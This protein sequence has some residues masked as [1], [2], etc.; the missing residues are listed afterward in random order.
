MSA[1]G[2]IGQPAAASW[3]HSV[4][5]DGRKRELCGPCVV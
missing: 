5:C 2:L 4:E 3:P 1:I